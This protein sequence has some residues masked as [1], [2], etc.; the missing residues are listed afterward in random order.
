VVTSA[1]RRPPGDFAGDPSRD[2]TAFTAPR[3]TANSSR[4][5]T[6]VHLVPGAVIADGRYRLLLFHGGPDGL[7][8]WQ[9][10]DTARDH[11]VALTFVGPEGTLPPDGVEQILARTLR[12]SRITMPGIAR[13][14]TPSALAIP[15]WWCRSGSVA[16]L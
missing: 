16:V 14:V 10:L 11:Q 6:E 7:Q 12:L 5:E 4:A 13:I 3:E 8:F 9:A 1:P 2:P 15:G